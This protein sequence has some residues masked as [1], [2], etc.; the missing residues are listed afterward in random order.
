[1]ILEENVNQ[2][3]MGRTQLDVLLKAE[4]VIRQRM[5]AASKRWKNQG[6]G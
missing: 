6:N 1:M 3:G 4:G 2:C 5:W